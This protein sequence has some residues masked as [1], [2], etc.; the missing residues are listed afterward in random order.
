MKLWILWKK[1]KI[2]EEKNPFFFPLFGISSWHFG[3]SFLGKY[4]SPFLLL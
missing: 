1:K 3:Y 4:L 2:G